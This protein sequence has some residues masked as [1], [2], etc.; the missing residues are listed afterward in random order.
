MFVITIG[1]RSSTLVFNLT[2]LAKG[3]MVEKLCA[4]FTHTHTHMYWFSLLFIDSKVL[5]IQHLWKQNHCDTV[6]DTH[7]HTPQAE[8]ICL[9]KWIQILTNMIIK[10]EK[11][12]LHSLK[13]TIYLTFRARF[14]M[15]P[16]KYLKM[17]RWKPPFFFSFACGPCLNTLFNNS[18][19]TKFKYPVP[20]WTHFRNKRE[21]IMWIM[22]CNILFLRLCSG[23]ALSDASVA[24]TQTASGNTSDIITARAWEIYIHLG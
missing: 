8:T 9:G 5:A 20:P 4:S 23:A 6:R 7:T 1:H 2:R 14:Q 21:G 16:F 13:R 22:S 11:Y 10:H 18:R 15:K 17:R 19:S 12:F 24:W 3:S